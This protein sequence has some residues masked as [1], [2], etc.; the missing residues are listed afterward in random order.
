MSFLRFAFRTLLRDL[1][2]GELHLLG[3]ALVV[4]VASQTSV[5][6]LTDRVAQALE[7]EANQLLGADLLLKSDHPWSPDIPQGAVIRGLRVVT[8]T[9]FSSMALG[10]QGAQLVGVKAVEV[11]YPLRGSLRISPGP[12]QPDRPAPGVPPRGEAWLDE[13]LFAALELK[14]GDSVGLGNLQLKASA[15][16][17]FESDRGANFFSALP[18]ILVNSEDLPAT[19]LIQEG[20]RVTWLLQIAGEPAAVASFRGW[21]KGRLER[22]QGAESVD[23]ARPEVRLALDQAQRFLRLA[24]LMAVVLAAVAVGLAARRFLRRHLDGC[25]VMRCLGARQSQIAR[26]LL[27]EFLIFG[28]FAA[29]LG[30]AAGWAINMAFAGTVVE[31]LNTPLPAPS[32]LPALHGLTI[33]VALLLGFA[34]PPLIRLAKVPT[35]RVLRREWVAVEPA[36]WLAWLLG[37]GVLAALLLWI[38][39]DLTLG[40][41]VT[42]GFALAV[43][44]YAGVAWLGLRLLRRLRAG[45][46]GAGWRFGLAALQRREGAT[47]IQIVALAVG[48]AALLLLTVVQSDLLEKWHR[49]APPDAPNRFIINIQPDQRQAVLE[50]FRREAGFEPRLLPMIRGRLVAIN[51]RPVSPEAFADQ[52]AQRLAQR[53]FNLSFGAALPEGNRIT[54]GLWHGTSAD[55][56]FSV[57]KG[58]AETLGVELGDTVSFMVAGQRVEAAITSVRE[59]AW[60]SMRVNFFF[61]ASPGLLEDYPASLITSFHLP[62]GREDLTRRLVAAFPNVS[63]IDVSAMLAQVQAMLDKLMSVVRWV[64][65]FALLA[66][67]AVL[68]AALQATQDER[69]FELA[70]LRTLGGRNGQLRLALL[71]E[72][73]VLGALAGILAGLGAT[74]LGWFLAESVFKLERYQPGGLA[75]LLGALA[76]AT[77]VM[78][79]GWLGARGLLRRPPLASLRGEG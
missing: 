46:R 43:A 32:W 17:S 22:G 18:R 33:G 54:E 45:P 25:A 77:G 20:S 6:F 74:G 58:I 29:G 34:L 71:T 56:Q 1:R 30:V 66:G 3:L 52:R 65:G 67:V 69:A 55:P 41:R 42:T 39:G 53:E 12:N 64:F 2:A 37:A 44:A 51:G 61:I 59:L 13:R 35:L 16:I 62:A 14:P 8:T 63:V 73:G 38:A 26:L 28:L 31:L 79:I 36:S 11:G 4:A 48:L 60:D 75:L 72:F 5:G 68:W 40:L 15:Q 27:L 24:A 23:N 76:G 70:M 78:A 47:V 50:F 7:R 10:P 57:E 9:L 19:G 49:S 21:M